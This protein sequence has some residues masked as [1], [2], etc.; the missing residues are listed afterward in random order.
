MK[1]TVATLIA[2]ALA[3]SIVHEHFAKEERKLNHK[4]SN[5]EKE[6]AILVKYTEK[7]GK[8]HTTLAEL[9]RDV[10]ECFSRLNEGESK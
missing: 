2:L 10:D 7:R 4:I 8:L 9:D 5:A 3:A 1:L 6:V